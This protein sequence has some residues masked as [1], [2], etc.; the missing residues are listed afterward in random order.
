MI[1]LDEQLLGR[2]LEGPIAAWYP[3]SVCF[4]NSLRPGTIIKDDAIPILLA[5]AAEPTFVTI[6]E[7]D[8]WQVFTPDVRYCTVCFAV[9][10]S[11]ARFLPVLLQR[12]FRHRQFDT[13][14][15]RMGCVVRITASGIAQFYSKQDATVQAIDEF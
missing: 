13:K 6:N 5:Q 2:G 7:G 1:V 10:S 8:F 11:Q 14:A 3:G 15:K 4:I 9:S 12:L